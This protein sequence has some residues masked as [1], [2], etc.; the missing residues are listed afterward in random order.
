MEE[1]QEERREMMTPG[2][3]QCYSPPSLL[4]PKEEKRKEDKDRIKMEAAP[5]E[6]LIKGE[7]DSEFRSLTHSDRLLL[8]A[9]FG[10]S[11]IEGGR[12]ATKTKQDACLFVKET[13]FSNDS[14]SETA[15]SDDETIRLD[16]IMKYINRLPSI[17]SN[18]EQEI[19]AFLENDGLELNDRTMCAVIRS[20]QKFE[21]VVPEALLLSQ[22]RNKKSFFL[23]GLLA[24]R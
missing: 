24:G 11:G 12:Q 4:P 21:R 1:E 18:K 6:D 23:S 22:R 7:L 14:T 8:R 2:G 5:R 20:F 13:L 9:F 17:F 16:E 10:F 3:D 19:K 15:G